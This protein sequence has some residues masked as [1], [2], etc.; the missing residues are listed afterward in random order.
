MMV[1]HHFSLVFQV[2]FLFSLDFHVCSKLSEVTP[3]Y[4]PFLKLC[5]HQFEQFGEELNFKEE[6][7]MN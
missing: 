1:L 6:Y 5:L 3:L 4:R 2:V 7:F